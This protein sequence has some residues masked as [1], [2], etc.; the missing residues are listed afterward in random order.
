MY[1]HI[2]Q[3]TAWEEFK[4]SYGTDAVRV[5]NLFYTKH[6]IPYTKL[7]Y[8][9]CPRVLPED[10]DFEA[11]RK[12]LQQNSCIAINFDVPNIV[13]GSPEEVA[14][15]KTFSDNCKKAVRSEFA[16]ANILIDLGRTEQELLASLHKKHKYNI[17][18]AQKNG[19][20]VTR[21]QTEEDFNVFY[22]LYSQTAK[23]QKY[24]GR[25]KEYLYLVWKTLAPKG[26]C[27]IL[28][29]S[30]ESTPLASWM[31]FV[32]DHVLYYPYGG[33][34]LEHK[35][36]F[37]SCLVGWEAIKLGKELNCDVFD[38]WGA[39]MDPNDS[40]D[41][42]YGF[43]NFKLKFGGRHVTYIDSYDLV[44]NSGAYYLFNLINLIRWKLLRH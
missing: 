30:Y 44:I 27:Y 2:V 9:Y 26:M 19:V 42:Y 4:K 6:R 10:I 29:A 31:L 39:A 18:Y 22:E 14:A 24:F 34:S 11:L 7:F 15:T 1:R 23:R 20:T 21:A 35:N 13:V 8:A 16:R 5:G 32:H 36:L 12:S 41:S 37:A 38:M 28:N 3:S 17:S 40:G 33:S 25:S 43:T